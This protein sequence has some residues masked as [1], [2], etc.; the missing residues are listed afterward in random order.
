MVKYRI[1]LQFVRRFLIHT[2]LQ[3]PMAAWTLGTLR[4]D[5][6]NRFHLCLLQD[7]MG[8]LAWV[9]QLASLWLHLLMWN[10]VSAGTQQ[11]SQI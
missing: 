9:S 5:K 6:T 7:I 4:Q 11:Y 2:V 1:P 10:K 8:W 3:D